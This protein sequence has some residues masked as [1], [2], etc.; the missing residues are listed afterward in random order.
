MLIGLD[1]L[2]QMM[3]QSSLNLTQAKIENCFVAAGKTA[4]C[5]I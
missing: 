5:Q 3:Y 1:T 4:H 2:G